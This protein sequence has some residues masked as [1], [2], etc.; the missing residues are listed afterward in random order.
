MT[1]A[2]I[3]EKV[4]AIVQQKTAA[5]SI[6]SDA[7]I[8]IDINECTLTLCSALTTLPKESITGLVVA[9]TITFGRDVLRLDYAAIVDGTT[10][11]IL[12]T[13]DFPN[14]VR[15]NPNWQQVTD[16]MPTHLVRM[17]DLTWMMYPPPDATWTGK[18]LSL[19]GSVTPDDLTAT[20][21]EPP[22]SRTMH[23]AYPHYCAWLFFL[24]LNNP[25]RAASEYAIFDSI[26]KT[27]TKTATSTK[28]SL[29]ALRWS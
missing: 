28:G 9:D 22:I 20:T 1:V 15:L 16:S 18:V 26:R 24:A 5:N 8:L 29:S 6:K 10:Y 13:I 17:T 27:N 2:Q 25:E 3:I 7:S 19:Y 23:H 14:F 21:E 11:H 12:D 4:R